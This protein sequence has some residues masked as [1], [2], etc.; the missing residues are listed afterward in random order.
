MSIPWHG[1]II[2]SEIFN[3]TD[4]FRFSILQHIEII[5]IKNCRSL[6]SV[7]TFSTW[8]MLI[9]KIYRYNYSIR[10]KNMDPSKLSKHHKSKKLNATLAGKNNFSSAHA[11][12]HHFRW[13]IFR[14]RVCDPSREFTQLQQ[15]FNFSQIQ[16]QI[17]QK[18]T[19]DCSTK[20][21]SIL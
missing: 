19:I 5:E 17:K 6:V 7:A 20:M 1:I 13:R 15:T 21:F 10:F 9:I 8:N 18:N 11:S 4:I 14:S 3:I 2:S 12:C 16:S